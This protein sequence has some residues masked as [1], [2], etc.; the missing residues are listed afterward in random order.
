MVLKFDS[1]DEIREYVNKKET[2]VVIYGAGMIGQIIMPYIVVEYG[3]VD[4]LLFYVDGDSKKQ[5][6]TIHIGNRNIEIKSLDVLSDI[7]ISNM[8]SFVLFFWIYVYI[9]QKFI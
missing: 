9:K 6:E 4:K 5:N 8:D 3:I 1:F 2:P 7:P